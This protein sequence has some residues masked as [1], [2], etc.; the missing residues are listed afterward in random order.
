MVHH[1]KHLAER[2]ARC[3]ERTT[4]GFHK[5]I[6]NL[7]AAKHR[8]ET[9]AKP[10]GRSVLWLDAFI[11]LADEMLQDDAREHI[12]A[13]NSFLAGLDVESVV[14]NA[15]MADASHE[16]LAFTRFL[17][18]DAMPVEDL[19]S[20]V[21]N[22][23][24][25]IVK[26][27]D[28]GAV[29]SVPGFTAFAVECLRSVRLIRLRDG[30]IT[31][32]GGP[33]VPDAA[34][35]QRCVARMRAWTKLATEIVKVEFPD[36]EIFQAFAALSLSKESQRGAPDAESV[37]Q[38]DAYFGTLAKRFKVDGTKLKVE[39]DDYKPLALKFYRTA[40]CSNFEAWKTALLQRRTSSTLA[41]HP[42]KRL[43]KVVMRMPIYSPS[44]SGVE[45][46]FS[47]YKALMGEMRA[48]MGET[49]EV[50][51]IKLMLD[52]RSDEEDDVI[53]MA[54]EIYRATYGQHQEHSTR[55][56]KGLVK[57]D[58]SKSDVVTETSWLQ[59]RREAVDKLVE[60]IGGKSVPEGDCGEYWTKK[61]EEELE[62]QKAKAQKLKVEA[63]G[64]DIL[65]D[66]YVDEELMQDA[67]KA[68]K[69]Q[70]AN[71]KKLEVN[72]KRAVDWVDGNM[73]KLCDMQGWTMY[74][75][76]CSASAEMTRALSD[77]EV[78]VTSQ[79]EKADVFVSRNPAALGQRSLWWASICG[80]YVLHPDL[81]LGSHGPA[82][83]Y[84]PAAQT[85]R[86]IWLSDSVRNKHES[87][88]EII[89]HVV[90]KMPSKWK[91]IR[92]SQAEF[93]AKFK[94][95]SKAHRGCNFIGIVGKK[96][97]K[98]PPHMQQLPSP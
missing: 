3:C 43:A 60:S 9:F 53:G 65:L 71:L 91:L 89:T 58:N 16:V 23:V 59:K 12:E 74:V 80:A 41:A 24:K 69:K 35:R 22:F 11:A 82:I 86:Q 21:D 83:K 97:N 90:D 49:T 10:G 85:A 94:S 26:L 7:S 70:E 68:A 79:R 40:S 67:A 28:E 15:L 63:L 45:Q 55:I 30:S 25:R 84:A 75:E 93:L 48:S 56:D 61:H 44:S 52:R 39:F 66:S 19:A 5:G 72:R 34:V 42:Q 47:R 78:S 13:A 77:A 8:Y 20:E 54:R 88:V 36:Y 18:D 32:L 57:K 4:N 46:S 27:F 2:F 92:G 87:T 98:V 64:D 76:K 6:S 33:G 37:L 1:S 38:Q 17:D 50:Q 81:M 51:A 73:P 31:S 29:F 62:W 96:E 14:Q 95:G